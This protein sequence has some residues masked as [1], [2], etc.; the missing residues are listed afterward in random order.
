MFFD[1]AE[2]RVTGMKHYCKCTYWLCIY[3]TK[4]INVALREYCV[5]EK[6][7]QKHECSISLNVMIAC[8]NIYIPIIND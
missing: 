3:L 6:N 2:C 7:V 1:E 4:V 8:T 5:V